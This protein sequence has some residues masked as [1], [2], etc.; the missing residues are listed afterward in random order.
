MSFEIPIFQIDEYKL[1]IYILQVNSVYNHG[2][3]LAPPDVLTDPIRFHNPKTQSFAPT[4]SV[5]SDIET[6][7]AYIPRESTGFVPQWL[8]S[9][10]GNSKE[11]RN[12]SGS[13]KNSS[14][15]S[16]NKDKLRSFLQ[17][18]QNSGS[19]S[20]GTEFFYLPRQTED[21]VPVELR[22]GNPPL[23]IENG[24][25]RIR[26]LNSGAQSQ[27]VNIGAGSELIRVSE[28]TINH[29]SQINK[30]WEIPERDTNDVQPSKAQHIHDI[31]PMNYESDP[32]LELAANNSV[33]TITN[34][35]ELLTPRSLTTNVDTINS[36]PESQ[37][38]KATSG[39][40]EDMATDAINYRSENNSKNVCSENTTSKT[41]S[42]QTQS[43]KF[44]DCLGTSGQ[45]PRV[46]QSDSTNEG[47]VLYQLVHSD[48]GAQLVPISLLKHPSVLSVQQT[49]PSQGQGQ[50]VQ[51]QGQYEGSSNLITSPRSQRSN[52]G[53]YEGS[54]NQFTS[55][56]SQRSNHDLSPPVKDQGA[57]TVKE[58]TDDSG[59][60]SVDTN[61]WSRV[62]LDA[63]LKRLHYLVKEIKECGK[64]SSKFNID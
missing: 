24:L 39:S 12:C 3:P 4:T 43:S 25:Y 52:Q 35:L 26:P 48:H 54:S 2:N 27:G 50:H 62:K 38:Q 30:T 13:D 60:F 10:V 42:F 15:S 16:T 51:S 33:S 14:G 29:G 64:I 21:A 34:N 28:P 7:Q 17:N 59:H 8:T 36:V 40:A 6:H 9:S 46:H 47:E 44:S 57:K 1:N 55:P 31:S 5:D 11:S 18:S 58:C 49:L 22:N 37:G 56:R 32:V 19:G 41:V 20:S 23:V 45:T 61:P 63:G 53:Q